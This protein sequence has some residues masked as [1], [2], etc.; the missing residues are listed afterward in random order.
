MQ[1]DGTTTTRAAETDAPSE[2][3]A[4]AQPDPIALEQLWTD[5]F[6]HVATLGV[7]G[8]GGMII[9]LQA[10]VYVPV[11][12]WWLPFVSFIISAVLAMY[13]QSVTIDDASRGQAPGR[14]AR[15]LRVAALTTL[16]F[17]GGLVVGGTLA[18][19]GGA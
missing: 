4:R 2:R 8:A 10:Q 6:Q 9:L 11:P 18:T 12:G 1:K 3:A 15:M 13:G 5:Q 7:A 17:A 16:G 19:P 14:K